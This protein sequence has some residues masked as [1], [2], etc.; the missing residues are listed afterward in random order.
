MTAE[1]IASGLAARRSGSGWM[2]KCPAHD[3]KTPSLSIGETDGKVL[4][5][6]NDYLYCF[7]K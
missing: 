4:L 6:T 7:G 2:A 5:R 1:C 3:D